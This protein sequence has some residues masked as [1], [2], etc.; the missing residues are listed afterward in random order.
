MPGDERA[1]SGLA[2]PPRPAASVTSASD[3]R[4]PLGVR[5]RGGL[6]RR[7]RSETRPRRARH[8]SRIVKKLN[9]QNRRGHFVGGSG[10]CCLHRSLSSRRRIA[11]QRRRRAA[12]SILRDENRTLARCASLPVT[13]GIHEACQVTGLQCERSRFDGE[14]RRFAQRDRSNAS[15][16]ARMCA[17]RSVRSSRTP[18]E[19]RVPGRVMMAKVS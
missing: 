2:D 6:D 12:C 9:R 13:V 3:S 19:S 15:A 17:S 16:T 4:M 11:L 14:K 5:L 7:P 1:G 8:G 10:T 18:G